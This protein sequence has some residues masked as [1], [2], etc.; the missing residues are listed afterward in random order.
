MEDASIA[1]NLFTS[2]KIVDYSKGRTNLKRTWLGRY[3]AMIS[4]I[5]MVGSDMEYWLDYGASRHVSNNRSMFATFKEHL[6]AKSPS[7]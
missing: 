3:I 4:E 2:R 6:M 1:R 5:N 7:W